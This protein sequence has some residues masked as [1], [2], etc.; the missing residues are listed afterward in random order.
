MHVSNEEFL[1]AFNGTE[2]QDT[3]V[4]SFTEDPGAPGNGGRWFGNRWGRLR[5]TSRFPAG[6]SYFCI[7]LFRDDDD[8]IARRRK[9]LFR[10]T[11]VIV[12]DDVGTKVPEARLIQAGM[13]EPSW[14]LETSPGNFQLGYMLDVPETDAGR[15]NALLDGMVKRGLCDDGKDPGMKGVTRFV[16]LPEGRN[17]KAK[18]GPGGFECRMASWNPERRY[19][20][21]E[22]ADPWGIVLPA[23]G[24]VPAAGLGGIAVDPADD[25]ILGLLG[26]WGMLT[27]ARTAKD[28]TGRPE[29]YLCSCPWVDEHTGREDTGAAYW[30]GGAFKCF[31]GHCSDRNRKDLETWADARLQ[32]ESGGLVRLRAWDFGV[33]LDWADALWALLEAGG[34]PTSQDIAQ[35]AL[36]PPR[37]VDEQLRAARAKLGTNT[38]PIRRAITRERHRLTRVQR[39]AEHAAVNRPAPLPA[40]YV[41]PVPVTLDESQAET[42]RVLQEIRAGFPAAGAASLAPLTPRRRRT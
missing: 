3:H 10:E 42:D 13:P 6:N 17:T 1:Q 9:A 25:E 7:S 34:V 12:V 5:D 8:G 33:V 2:W 29:G 18:Y 19:R 36:A 16:R 14:R 28:N 32:E 21:E 26:R 11:R 24:A 31:H 20:M 41:A 37:D 39:E 27:G 15:V 22:L 40:G 4:T 23:P 38:T 30:L 35:L